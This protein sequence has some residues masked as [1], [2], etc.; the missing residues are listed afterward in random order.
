MGSDEVNLIMVVT[1]Q[2]RPTNRKPS[3]STAHECKEKKGYCFHRR[4][5]SRIFLPSG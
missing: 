4:L 2:G 3:C 5:I 1:Q